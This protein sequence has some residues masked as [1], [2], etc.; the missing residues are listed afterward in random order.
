MTKYEF[1]CDK[2]DKAN[3]ALVEYNNRPAGTRT[4][5]KRD[6][7]LADIDAANIAVRDCPYEAIPDMTA[8]IAKIKQIEA[9]SNQQDSLNQL[10]KEV[11]KFQPN[12][13][14]AVGMNI[15]SKLNLTDSMFEQS[16]KLSSIVTETKYN[17]LLDTISFAS[18]KGS[19][20]A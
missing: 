17:D 4:I 7:L 12:V 15:I 11:I 8:K 9:E 3:K 10:T 5:A 6:E 19:V 1:L 16:K 14:A 2:Q 20:K 13:A 18:L